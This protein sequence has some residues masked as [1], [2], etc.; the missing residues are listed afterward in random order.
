M[1]EGMTHDFTALY[2]EASKSFGTTNLPITQHV[3][4]LLESA[5]KN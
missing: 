5:T 2:T 1:D 4:K 3:Q